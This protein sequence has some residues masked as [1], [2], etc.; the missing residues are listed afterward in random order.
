MEK[1]EMMKRYEAETGKSARDEL[2]SGSMKLYMPAN[3][4]ITWLEAQ[5]TWRPVTQ[6][7]KEESLYFLK[8]ILHERTDCE[9]TEIITRKYTKDLGWGSFFSV[10]RL[11]GWLPIP[12]APEGERRWK[13]LK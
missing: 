3:D 8:V 13:R 5:L 2:Y 1:T 11:L 4:Y 10:T 9:H 7:P 6:R 12:P